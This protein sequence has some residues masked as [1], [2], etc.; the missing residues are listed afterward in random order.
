M[1]YNDD[2]NTKSINNSIVIFLILIV[3]WLVNSCACS[4][5]SEAC[6][7][8]SKIVNQ[9]K[10]DTIFS[11]ESHGEFVIEEDIDLKGMTLLMPDDVTLVHKKGLIK[12]GTLIGSNTRIKSSSALFEHVHIKG[13]WNVPNVSSTLFTDLNYEN[14]LRDVMGL[15]NSQIINNVIIGEGY[16][17]FTPEKSGDEY[18]CINSNTNLILNGTIEITPNPFKTYHIISIEGTNIKVSGKGTIIGDKLNHQGTE[19][20]WGIGIYLSNALRCE[21]LGL[22]VK[23]CWGDCVYV[24]K[25]SKDILLSGL[26]LENGRRQGI[27]ITGGENI[28]VVNTT[29]T[30]VSGTAPAYAIDVEPNK[31]NHIRNVTIENV[32][33]KDCEGGFVV[34]VI[35]PKESSVDGVVFNKCRIEGVQ[36]KYALRLINC[37]NVLV[38]RSYIGTCNY[39]FNC[40]FT[41]AEGVIL[42]NNEIHT[43]DAVVND[44]SGVSLLGNDIYGN[45]ICPVSIKSFLLSNKQ[46]I[47]N[48]RI[49]KD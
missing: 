47:K 28:K 44:I 49:H 20:E 15:T 2:S 10:Y 11:A 46:R 6:S 18:V 40:N 17:T 13:S 32:V 9:L 48:N 8:C 29:I 26:S 25:G 42:M 43:K 3:L 14:S 12:N 7:Q 16:Y 24:G 22:T 45:K 34:S 38:K 19:G 21:V 31:Q 37:K 1:K 23:D 41:K 4:Y 5:R 27:S 36:K 35:H 30:G 39:S 33:A